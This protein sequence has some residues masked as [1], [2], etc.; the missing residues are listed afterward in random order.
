MGT[1][2]RK[3]GLALLMNRASHGPMKYSRNRKT[4]RIRIYS[5]ISS[6]AT[7][8]KGKHVKSLDVEIGRRLKRREKK[9]KDNGNERA[10][11]A[12]RTFASDLRSKATEAELK[13]QAIARKKKLNLKFKC[14]IFGFAAGV[15]DKFYIVDFCDQ[16][17]RIIIEI[18]DKTADD[19]GQ[20]TK[21]EARIAY[22]KKLRYA[23]KMISKE[24]ILNGKSTHFLYDIYKRIGIDL[25]APYKPLSR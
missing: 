25:T 18:V 21:D 17:H 15:I 16:E 10:F 13:F 22:L 1:F 7:N 2:P 11:Q 20:R 23:V 12:A 4:Y 8:T 6:M 14:P 3:Q 24:D 5:I 9:R 19:P